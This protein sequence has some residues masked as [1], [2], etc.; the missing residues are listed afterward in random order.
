MSRITL[1]GFALPLLISL[2]LTPASAPKAFGATK[3]TPESQGQTGTL[4]KMIVANGSV[5]MDLD[6]NRLN[7]ISPSLAKPVRR[8]NFAVGGQFL[9]PDS[10]FQRSVARS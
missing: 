6:L 5:T 8:C 7:G 2:C 1:T 4:Q 3:E 10:G 9:F